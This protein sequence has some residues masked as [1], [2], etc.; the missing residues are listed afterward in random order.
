MSQKCSYEQKRDRE[1]N[2]IEREAG[3]E[4]D[5]EGSRG[6]M[7]AERHDEVFF[8]SEAAYVIKTHTRNASACLCV[9]NSVS[10]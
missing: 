7:C 2:A 6:K 5:R 1:M 4:C 9:F 10:G 3:D 8:S